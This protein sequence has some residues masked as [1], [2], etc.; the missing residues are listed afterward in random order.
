MTPRPEQR[1][2]RRRLRRIGLAIVALLL[3]APSAAAASRAPLDI[4]VFARIGPPGQP[5]PVAIGPDGR[6]YVGTNQ[7][8]HGDADAPSRIFAFSPGG[9]LLREYELTG[10]PLSENHGIQGLVFDRDGLLYALDR[11]ADPRVVVLDPATGE[12]WRY[13]SFRDVPPCDGAPGG[14]CS[15]T[16][17]DGP[18][19]P[20]YAVFSSSGDL[21]VTD[22]D[23]GLI[24]R[25]PPGGGEAEIWLSDPRLESLYGPNGI[26]FM[27]DAK[28][29]LFA[30]TASNPAAGNPSTGRLYTVPVQSDG[31]PG[32]LT[33]VWESRP[34]DAPDGIAIARSGNVYV[35]LAG[36]NQIVLLSPEFVEL[37]RAPADAL[38]NEAE[39]VP[40]DG[41]GSLAFLDDRLLVSNHSP[42]RGDPAS[43]AILDVFAGEPGLPLHYPRIFRPELKI[44]LLA[45]RSL[46]PKRLRLRV[47]VTRDLAAIEVPV[48]GAKVRARGERA[49]TNERGVGRLVVRPWD[50]RQIAVKA[51]KPGFADAKLKVP[52]KPG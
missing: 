29:L 25:V 16:V 1:P 12:Q 46:A 17:L 39:E 26:Q 4:Q 40:L 14:D 42:I 15:Q 5:E 9:E 22:I 47:R 27:A 13:A 45:V 43:W 3:V 11:S 30:N 19:G 50:D 10:Q 44:E 28:T 41:P 38:A 51:R 49:R 33:Q 18:A 6:V 20:D 34:L 23:Q 2:R 31:S 24:W 35:A 52:G 32:A 37:A 36:A 21:Y 8:G 48:A 7:L